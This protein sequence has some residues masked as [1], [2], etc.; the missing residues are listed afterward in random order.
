MILCFRF[1]CS[2]T[3]N[4]KSIINDMEACGIKQQEDG[5][6]YV[7]E[8]SGIE[9]GTAFLCSSDKWL[10]RG[11]YTVSVVYEADWNH[12]MEILPRGGVFCFRIMR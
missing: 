12:S 2:E 9:A 10:G 8:N 11:S 3:Y 5:V 6:W 7:D 4:P 1:L